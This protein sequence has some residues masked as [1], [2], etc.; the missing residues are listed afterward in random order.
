MTAATTLIPGLDEIVRGGD[1]KRRADAARR[2]SELFLQGAA[3][4][5]ADHV[6]LFDGVLTSL[7]PHTELSARADLAERL[8]QLA[9][10]PRGLVGQLAHEDEIAIAGP[11]LRRSPVIDEKVLIEIA[12]AKGQGHLLA[13]SERPALSPDLT[14]VIVRR[15]DRDVVRRAAGNAGAR[16]STTGYST[17]IKR[18]GQD[19]V[20]TLAVGQRD[21]LSANQLKDL[22]AGSIDVVRRRLFDVVKPARQSAIKQAMTEISGLT[23]LVVSQRDFAPAQRTVLALHR[24]GALGEGALLNFAKAFKYEE[25]IAALSAMTGV[26]IAT[27]D[28]LISGDRYDPILIAG[29]AV[30]LEWA[31]VRALILLRLGPSRVASPADIESARMNFARLMPST[32]E[33]VVGFWKL[34]PPG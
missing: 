12:A 33:R 14:D 24:D 19:G 8:S 1:P 5:R 3:T 15:G 18:A 13:M 22:L 23:E 20:L 29:K 4:F 28:R 7:V 17:L 31:T 30:G 21:D 16:F 26:K 2:I 6:D 32:A 10:A 11:L 9:N 25:S 34:R 27:L